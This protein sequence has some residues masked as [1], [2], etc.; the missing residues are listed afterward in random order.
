MSLL[1]SW[2]VLTVSVGVTATVLPGFKVR[3]VPGAIKV[4]AIFGVL[5]WAIGWLIFGVIGIA[6]LGLGFLFAFVTRWVTNA[7]L[8]KVADAISEDLEIDGFGRAFVGGLFMS[9][10]GTMLELALGLH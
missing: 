7:I 5:N 2:F 9:G 6:S 4:A 10:L 8:L 3:G 1:L